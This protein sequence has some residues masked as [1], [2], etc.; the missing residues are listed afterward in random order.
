MLADSCALR[1]MDGR[2]YADHSEERRGEIRER[3]A[4]AHRRIIR[5]AGSHHHSAQ[6]LN[7]G[8][9][10]FARARFA[11]AAEAGDG[12]VDDA[13]IQFLREC[14][15]DAQTL[16]RA[17]AEIFDDHVGGLHQVGIHAARFGMLQ[18]QRHAQ[19]VAK[20]VERGDGNIVFMPP[21]Q[22]SSLRTQVGRIGAA[23]IAS[24]DRVLNLDDLGSETREQQ[25]GEGAGEGR[26][27][28]E[29]RDV[30]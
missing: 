12:A 19:L 15:A 14:V 4:N 3:H 23:A 16:E 5:T 22:S 18:V 17:T 30:L 24:A 11:F 9:H 27:Q 13:R 20:P 25:S 2:Q 10:G 21:R 29:D 28:I 7:D 6:R 8:V 26:G 1:L